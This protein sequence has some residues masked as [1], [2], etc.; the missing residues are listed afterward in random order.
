M[1]DDTVQADV[2]TTSLEELGAAATIYDRTMLASRAHFSSKRFAAGAVKVGDTFSIDSGLGGV[3]TIEYV[4]HDG[5]GLIFKR[6][7]SPGWP[8]ETFT[9]KD[10]AEAAACIRVPIPA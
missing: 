4:R 7:A 8:A 6:P 9:Y 1:N 3:W 5:E 10:A 2:E